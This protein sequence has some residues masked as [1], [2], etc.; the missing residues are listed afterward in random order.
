MKL[1]VRAFGLAF[2]VLLGLTL[3][4]GTIYSVALG[5]GRTYYYYAWVLP[6]L[7]RNIFG[8][9]YGLVGGLIE[10]FLIGAFFAWL[11]NRFCTALYK[12]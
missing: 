12:T 11:Y 3:C 8:I 2:G 4:L 5:I 7:G 10:G 1:R 9:V 6:F